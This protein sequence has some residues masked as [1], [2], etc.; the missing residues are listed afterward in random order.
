MK[1]YTIIIPQRDCADLTKRCLLSI[2]K[3][4]DIEVFIIDDNSRR[5]EDLKLVEKEFDNTIFKFIYTTEG[6]GAGYA[7]NIGLKEAKGEWL[8]FSD[9]DDYF[10]HDAFDIFDKYSCL[11]YDYILYYHTSVYS[12][13]LEPCIRYSVRNK[14]IDRYFQNPSKVNEDSLKYA[15]IV[16]WAKMMKRSIAVNNGLEFD[17][18]P[19]SNDVT[20]ISQIAYH[21]QRMAVVKEC[22]YVLTFR[23]GSIT[24]VNNKEN[25][26]SR[27]L[28]S[29]RFNNF[30]KDIGCK[31]L[32]SRVLSK[33]LKALHTF[34]IKEAL[35][36]IKTAHK[37]NQSLFTGL[38]FSFESIKEKMQQ[39]FRKDSF[40]G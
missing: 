8:I 4:Y 40:Q 1:K 21:C 18:V 32:Q 33:V 15:D 31:N 13:T 22:V 9:A 23:S 36:Y 37:Y 20:F 39:L 11:S 25:D 7:R 38:T 2:P 27:F 24:R 28:V 10:T 26:Y 6:K 19:A 16:P 5:P 14:F 34:G 17:E 30:L 3:R 35:M 29:L 12:D